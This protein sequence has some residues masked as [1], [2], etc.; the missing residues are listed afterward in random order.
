METVGFADDAFDTD[1]LMAEMKDLCVDQDDNS[2][3]TINEDPDKSSDDS[4]DE[5]SVDDGNNEKT[6]LPT[7]AK[8]YL[9]FIFSM[10]EKNA[11]AVRFVCA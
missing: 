3:S 4:S 10:W 1:I 7:Q 5:S 9:V 6:Q 8:H 2:L 11:K